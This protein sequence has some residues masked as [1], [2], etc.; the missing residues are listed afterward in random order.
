VDKLWAI[1]AIAVLIGMAWVGFKIE[2]HWVAK[3]GK[4]FLCNGQFL[5]NYGNALSR[6]HETRVSVMP[7][8]D[9]IVDQ[10]KFMRHR[11]TTWRMA[12]ESPES[13]QKR[14][15]FVLRIRESLGAG[16]AGRATMLALRLPAGSRAVEALRALT[17]PQ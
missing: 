4:R 5:D 13:P 8:G 14:V 2:P 6:W 15:V 9:L 10:K 17:T 7:N 16:A 12:A 1:L 11:T 3:D